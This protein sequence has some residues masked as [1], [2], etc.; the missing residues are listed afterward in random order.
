MNSDL[1]DP[2][3][4][5]PF[6]IWMIDDDLICHFIANKILSKALIISF[7]IVQYERASAALDDF[8]NPEVDKPDLVILD[9][10]MPYMNG[11]EFLQEISSRL[12]DCKVPIAVVSATTDQNEIHSAY[13]HPLV[14]TF[15]SKPL[16]KSHV[17]EIVNE[18]TRI[19][20]L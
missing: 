15:C 18:I 10:N 14:F 3:T 4:H 20:N 6:C 13:S 12:P 16:N 19:V 17:T 8:R 5:K 2:A 7:K 1:T 9:L 11:L